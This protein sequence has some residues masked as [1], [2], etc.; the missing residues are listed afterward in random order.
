M[1]L[2]SGSISAR[3]AIF[4]G[5]TGQSAGETGTFNLTGGTLTTAD[6]WRFNSQGTY[7]FNTNGGTIAPTGTIS[8]F[9]EDNTTANNSQTNGGAVTYAVLAGGAI[10]NTAGFNVTVGHA[11]AAAASNGGLTKN[12]LG[13]SP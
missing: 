10:F 9:L 5:G 4:N 11:L 8:S 12:G 13:T 2:N 1:N 6:V 7:T 3:E